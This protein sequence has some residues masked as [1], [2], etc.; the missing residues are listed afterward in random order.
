[1]QKTLLAT[2][3]VSVL[4]LACGGASAQSNSLTTF[5]S[6]SNLAPLSQTA[7]VLNLE[8]QMADGSGQ[9]D[10]N[11]FNQ[12][13]LI[14][15]T[16]KLVVQF[17]GSLA[18]Q[19]QKVLPGWMG[20]AQYS[21]HTIS[22]DI[23]AGWQAVKAKFSLTNAVGGVVI[24]KTLNTAQLVYDYRVQVS[25]GSSV[26]QEYLYTPANSGFQMGVK[27]NCTWSLS[28]FPGAMMGSTGKAAMM[29]HGSK[30][31]M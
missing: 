31:K 24:Y 16:G 11:S 23:Q 15:G 12:F 26:C 4:A 1:M 30:S 18:N 13:F 7:T 5:F 3:A 10:V 14:N 8:A 6:S 28:S 19:G 20:V 22:S 29:K 25:P 2:A 27:T 9:Q 17:N 21:N